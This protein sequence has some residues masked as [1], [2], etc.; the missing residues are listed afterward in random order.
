MSFKTKEELRSWAE[1]MK[2]ARQRK[3]ENKMENTIKDTNK[4][5]TKHIKANK[6]IENKKQID[7]VNEIKDDTHIYS[8]IMDLQKDIDYLYTQLP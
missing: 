8:L 1:Q 6:V 7:H 2:L 4:E 3:R 5:T